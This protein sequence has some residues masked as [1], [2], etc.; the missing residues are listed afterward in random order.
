M[1]V[2]HT[3]I[4]FCPEFWKISAYYSYSVRDIIIKY[5]LLELYMFTFSRII[6]IVFFYITSRSTAIKLSLDFFFLQV[7]MLLT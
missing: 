4:L 1:H 2:S 3:A 6:V 5:E 7:K